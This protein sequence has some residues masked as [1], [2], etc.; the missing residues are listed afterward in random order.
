MIFSTASL[1][2]H[3]GGW[4][5]MIGI[6]VPPTVAAAGLYLIAA[7]FGIPTSPPYTVLAV[8]S[9]LITL[10]VYRAMSAIYSAFARRPLDCLQR[11]CT[12]WTV[13]VSCLGV[14]GCALQHG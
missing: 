14:I 9:F 3:R 5:T 12:A 7:V 4:L 2:S 1:P 11:A 8:I 10:A 13:V 6:L